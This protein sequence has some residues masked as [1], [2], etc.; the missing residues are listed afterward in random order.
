MS[1][2][3]HDSIVKWFGYETAERGRRVNELTE[4]QSGLDE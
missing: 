2:H 3:S 1:G 4:S